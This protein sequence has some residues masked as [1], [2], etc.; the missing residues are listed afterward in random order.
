VITEREHWLSITDDPDWR[1][2]H[3]NDP[4]IPLDETLSAIT[5]AFPP[6]PQRILEIGCGYGRLTAK[7]ATMYPDAQV[8]GTDINPAILPRSDAITYLCT[9]T[10]AGLPP[11]DAIYSVA[12]FQHLTDMQKRDYIAQAAELLTPGGVLRVQFIAGARDN[13]CDHWIAEERM[14]QWFSGNGLTVSVDHA[15]AHSQWTW[16]TGTK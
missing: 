5:T 14:R 10:L 6:D 12:V 8:T 1:R 13:F 16:M 11:Q 9:D 15:L 4:G 7:I 2:N 3:I